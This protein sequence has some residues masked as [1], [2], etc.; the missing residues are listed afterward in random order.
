MFEIQLFRFQTV[1][2]SEHKPAGISACSDFGIFGTHTKRSDFR[3]C[4]KSECWKPLEGV[5]LASKWLA[6]GFFGFV[7][8]LPH[9]AHA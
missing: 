4:L 5:P 3:Q 9:L 1:P 6:T 8:I 7:L 2:K